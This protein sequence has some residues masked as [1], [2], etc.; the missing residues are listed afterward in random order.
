MKKI[1]EKTFKQAVP[2]VSTALVAG[3]IAFIQSILA[4][5]GF[6]PQPQMSNQEVGLLGGGLKVVHQAFMSMKYGSFT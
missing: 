1:L 6:C 5:Q 2:V 4:N 3:G